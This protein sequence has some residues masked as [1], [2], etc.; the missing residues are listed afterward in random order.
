LKKGQKPKEWARRGLTLARIIL[1]HNKNFSGAC[2]KRERNSK[3]RTRSGATTV[4]SY[5]GSRIIRGIRNGDAP[6]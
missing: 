3:N 1:H 6:C 2:P 5:L 4:L